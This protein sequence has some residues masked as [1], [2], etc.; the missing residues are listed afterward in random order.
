MYVK[1]TTYMKIRHI[2]CV[3]FL[4]PT[5]KFYLDILRHTKDRGGHTTY[6]KYKKTVYMFKYM[7]IIF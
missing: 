3:Y 2:I 5:Y 1:K 4:V 6:E 7:Y